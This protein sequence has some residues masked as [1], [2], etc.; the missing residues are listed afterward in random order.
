MAR[1]RTAPSPLPRL[2]HK[3]ICRRRMHGKHNWK[4]S[5]AHHL[6]TCYT[7]IIYDLQSP[8]NSKYNTGKKVCLIRIRNHSTI[9]PGPGPPR[10]NKIHSPKLRRRIFLSVQSWSY[11]FF[12]RDFLLPSASH[13]TYTPSTHPRHR[14]YEQVFVVLPLMSK[15]LGQKRLVSMMMN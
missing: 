4:V 6:H 3:D 5:W 10:I 13:T 9:V 8:S 2:H 14:P 12:I 7:H 15:A 1:G 11:C